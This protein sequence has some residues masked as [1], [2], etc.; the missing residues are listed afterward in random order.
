MPAAEARIQTPNAARYLNQLSDHLG[1]M[2][3][4]VPADRPHGT[5]AGHA[6]APTVSNVDRTDDQAEIQFD[7]GRCLLSAS[8]DAL[9]IRA[10]A[11]DD[12]ALARGTDLLRHRVETIGRRESLAV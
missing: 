9:T 8:S 11:A 7:W 4:G 12:D 10:E 1:H 5:G 3:R 6:G 2:S